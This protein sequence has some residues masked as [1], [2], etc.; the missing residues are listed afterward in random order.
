[1]RVISG[2]AKGRK[3]KAPK[4]GL[5]PLSDRA[6]ESL[7]NILA[8]KI[9]DCR[10]LDLFA[11]T[12]AVG[13]EALS[14]GAKIAFFVERVRST[15]GFIYENLKTTGLNADAE[16]FSLEVSRAL[17]L[18]D[19]KGAKF[20]IIYAGAPYGS[21]DLGNALEFLGNSSLLVSGTIVVAEH[22]SQELLP[23]KFSNLRKY[24]ESKQG[25]TMF[26]F[27]NVEAK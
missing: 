3:L 21:A 24:R 12:G 5:R 16:V 22:R 25:D 27:Y 1:M 26:S 10:F 8:P 14:R 17:K 20:D 4:S 7:F 9:M 2:L 23:E 6:K 13:I 19:S 11:G 15:A 18:L